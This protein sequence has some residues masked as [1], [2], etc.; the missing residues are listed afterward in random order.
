MDKE[1]I[2]KVLTG[3]L[4]LILI[5]SIM[6]VVY[7]IKHPKQSEYF[8]EFYILGKNGMAYDYPTELYSGESGN[9]TI[10]IVNHEGRNVT[11]HGETWLIKSNNTNYSTINAENAVMLDNYSVRLEP[12]PL[13]VEGDWESQFQKNYSFSINNSG[14]YQMWFF[15]FKDNVSNKNISKKLQDANNNTILSLK[16]NIA[17]LNWT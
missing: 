11:Y 12:K 8:S 16:L 4:L 15:L 3:F 14:D 2:N 10:G 13:I 9:L 17:V 6:G 5:I 7:I 1:N